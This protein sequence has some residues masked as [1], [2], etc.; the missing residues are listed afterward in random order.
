MKQLGQLVAAVVLFV[1][2]VNVI[3]WVAPIVGSPG[4]YRPLFAILVVVFASAVWRRIRS[5]P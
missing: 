3:W 4:V 2:A 5:E 1:V